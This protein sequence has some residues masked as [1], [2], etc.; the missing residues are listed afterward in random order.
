[1]LASRRFMR[2][3]SSNF[4]CSLGVNVPSDYERSLYVPYIIGSPLTAA[5]GVGRLGDIQ[6]GLRST[7]L[8]PLV[9]GG[10]VDEREVEDLF[11][12]V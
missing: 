4:L 10:G 6:R 7:Y 11:E 9:A 2:P 1:M 3:L 8:P 5:T 12:S